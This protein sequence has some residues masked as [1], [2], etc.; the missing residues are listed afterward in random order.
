MIDINVDTDIIFAQNCGRALTAAHLK[1]QEAVAEVVDPIAIEHRRFT[2]PKMN[3]YIESIREKLMSKMNNGEQ[4]RFFERDMNNNLT[5]I[6]DDVA[7]DNKIYKRMKKR[8]NYFTTKNKKGTDESREL[9]IA[10]RLMAEK[11]PNFLK[12]YARKLK[13]RFDPVPSKKK[14]KS[15]EKKKIPTPKKASIQKN[16]KTSSQHS[17]FKKWIVSKQKS[18]VSNLELFDP[19][20]P[21]QPQSP[22]PLQPPWQPLL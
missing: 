13:V 15:K 9:E 7:I 6:S 11:D 5:E 12:K 3:H 21:L 8:K 4:P 18:P 14:T 16:K 2:R 22:P 17:K 10:M 20:L 19:S 1:F